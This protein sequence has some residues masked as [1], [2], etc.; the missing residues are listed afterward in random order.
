MTSPFAPAS[1]GGAQAADA[2][3]RTSSAA[4]PTPADAPDRPSS[5]VALDP[6]AKPRGTSFRAAPVELEAVAAPDAPSCRRTPDGYVVFAVGSTSYAV[7]V[8]EVGSVLR[9]E[10]LEL[11]AS[12]QR[13][14]YGRGVALVD[15]RGRAIPVVDLRADPSRP[16]EV[17][18]PLYRHHVGLVVDRVVAVRPAEDLVPEPDGLPDV[19]PEYAQGI[20]RPVDGGPHLL[21]VAM[22]DAAALEPTT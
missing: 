16:G 2:P 18:L 22:P 17:L 19:L 8:E 11:L 15:V 6:A 1:P 5:V 4:S 7:P 21:L 13:P 14:R 3:A 12:P 20:L 10:S 9:P